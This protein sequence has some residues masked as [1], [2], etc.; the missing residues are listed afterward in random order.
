MLSSRIL[1]LFTTTRPVSPVPLTALTQEQP[2]TISTCPQLTDSHL[3]L[4]VSMLY[5]VLTQRWSRSG[6][7]PAFLRELSS[8][9]NFRGTHLRTLPFSP[10]LLT[11]AQYLSWYLTIVVS[12]MHTYVYALYT[13]YCQYHT[14]NRSQAIYLRTYTPTYVLWKCICN[15]I[16]VNAIHTIHAIPTQLFMYFGSVY[17]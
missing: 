12:F 14:V 13:S 15:A 9:L 10:C 17:V 3:T 5:T 11:I 7:T 6:K 8:C 2:G 1:L 4:T 16:P